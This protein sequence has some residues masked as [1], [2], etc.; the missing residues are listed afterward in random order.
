MQEIEISA[1]TDIIVAGLLIF[2]NKVVDWIVLQGLQEYPGGFGRIS[3]KIG[4]KWV[5]S[6][7]SGWISTYRFHTEN[8]NFR[9]DWYLRSL[10]SELDFQ[11]SKL[12]RFSR[13]TRISGW[14]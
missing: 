6:S 5:I 11:W 14:F 2:N 9:W 13:A 8:H 3:F 7:V 12:N 10:T 1:E 4:C